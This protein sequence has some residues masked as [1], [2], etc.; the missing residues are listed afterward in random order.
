[1]ENYNKARVIRLFD[2][3]IFRPIRPMAYPLLNPITSDKKLEIG[4]AEI[5][6]GEF[7]ES[8]DLL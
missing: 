4:I 2:L 5:T 6:N 1:L 7:D 3:A 8:L